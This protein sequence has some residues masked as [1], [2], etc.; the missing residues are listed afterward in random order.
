MRQLDGEGA[1]FAEFRSDGYL[2]A[3]RECEM[4]HDCQAQS[5]AAQL[6]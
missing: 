1:A 5:N 6:A 3:V 4:L 2:T